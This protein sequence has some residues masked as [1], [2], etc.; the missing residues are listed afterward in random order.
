MTS[1]MTMSFNRKWFKPRSYIPRLDLIV[2]VKG[3]LSRTVGSNNRPSLSPKRSNSMEEW[4]AVSP[5]P[6]E[7]IAE[8]KLMMPQIRMQKSSYYFVLRQCVGQPCVGI[9]PLSMT[10][11]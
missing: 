11:T 4:T 10:S 9:V 7:S 6:Q 8:Q 5:E 3:V 2:R 1:K